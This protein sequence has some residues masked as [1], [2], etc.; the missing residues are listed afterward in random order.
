MRITIL[1]PV[2]SSLSVRM[3]IALSVKSLV[4]YFSSLLGPHSTGSRLGSNGY[5]RV[6]PAES[7]CCTAVLVSDENG[8]ILFIV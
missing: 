1:K 8:L 3:S 6:G 2:L 5:Q 7:Y 4:Q